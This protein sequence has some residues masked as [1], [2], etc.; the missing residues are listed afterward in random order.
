M[1]IIILERME[2]M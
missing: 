2:Y 1:G